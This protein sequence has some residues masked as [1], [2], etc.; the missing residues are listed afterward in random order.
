MPVDRGDGSE[1][2]ESI[3][4]DWDRFWRYE[5]ISCNARPE[6]PKEVDNLLR[7]IVWSIVSKAADRSRSIRAETCFLSMANR[8]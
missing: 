8:R 2:W 1:E 3:R 4:T 5:E 7:R 6:I